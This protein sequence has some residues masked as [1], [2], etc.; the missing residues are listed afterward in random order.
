MEVATY[1]RTHTHTH[2]RTLLLLLVGGGG[3]RNIQ[4]SGCEILERGLL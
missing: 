3:S 1:A 2:A 4:Q